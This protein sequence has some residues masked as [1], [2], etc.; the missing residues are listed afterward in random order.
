MIPQTFILIG[1]SGCGKGTQGELLAKHLKSID[2]EKREIY[3]LET[4]ANFR[5]FFKEKSY[6]AKLAKNVYEKDE[7]QPD[8]IAVWMWAHQFL[9]D[10]K[11]D[12]HLFADGTCRSLPEAEIFDTALKFYNRKANVIYIDVS[13]KWSENHL[14]KR[15]REDDATLG[16]IERRL[17]W[18]D[19]DT[20]KAI[21]YYSTHPD[22]NF[23]KV[24]GEQSIEKVHADIVEKIRIFE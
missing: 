3:Y 2:K 22:Y 1:R 23:V 24:S 17:N 8:F 10:L 11:E 15:G 20:M 19:R 18:F 12:E 21:D 6:S 13:R 16:K 9:K 14:L 4:G 7:R 5:E